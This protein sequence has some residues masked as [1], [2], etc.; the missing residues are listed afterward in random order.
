V[1]LYNGLY[2]DINLYTYNQLIQII[3]TALL[4]IIDN[5]LLVM[6]TYGNT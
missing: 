2:M 3:G 4:Y 6:R 1:L 5:N